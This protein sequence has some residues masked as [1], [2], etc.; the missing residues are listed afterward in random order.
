MAFRR[1]IE[2]IRRK[3]LGEEVKEKAEKQLF[4]RLKNHGI[5]ISEEKKEIVLEHREEIEKVLNKAEEAGVQ[6]KN[7]IGIGDPEKFVD[8]II[9][10]S[11]FLLRVMERLAKGGRRYRI[12]DIPPWALYFSKKELP[13]DLKKIG[14]ELI[15][16]YGL[17]EPGNDFEHRE[18]LES[19]INQLIGSGKLD[20]NNVHVDLRELLRFLERKDEES[21][22]RALRKREEVTLENLLRELKFDE[23]LINR[24]SNEERSKKI[25]V[26]RN[27][28]GKIILPE[29]VESKFN[30]A[31]RL[32]QGEVRI[33]S[34]KKKKQEAKKYDRAAEMIRRAL[35]IWE[36]AH[37]HIVPLQVLEVGEGG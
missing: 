11:N 13:E 15:R 37:R 35:K 26:F 1:A 23:E 24:F 9:N 30:Y 36:K 28:N 18:I 8:Q 25:S 34:V 22:R 17:H 7:V 5:E 29:E 2:R 27:V 19:V 21:A 3:I 4:E 31:R 10:N 12:G 32:L 33:G 20:K 6:L 16:R 14:R